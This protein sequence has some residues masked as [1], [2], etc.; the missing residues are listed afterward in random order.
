MTWADFR[1]FDNDGPDGIPNS[2]DDDGFIDGLMI[3][4]PTTSN[5]DVVR[6]QWNI[7]PH[8]GMPWDEDSVTDDIGINGQYLRLGKYCMQSVL[9]THPNELWD[10]EI[11]CRT[12]IHEMG[13]VSRLSRHVLQG[14]P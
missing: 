1:Q 13:H 10:P 8:A 6:E 11:K 9:R 3:V 14:E 7:W 12:F 5:Y 4:P 2:G